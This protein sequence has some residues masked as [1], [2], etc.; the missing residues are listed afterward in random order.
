MPKVLKIK[1]GVEEGINDFLKFLLESGKVKGIFTL[2][3]TNENGAVSYSLITHLDELKKAVPLFPL[4]PVNAG[5]VLSAFTL[6]EATKDTVAAV[7]RPCEIRSFIELVKRFQ[8]SMENFLLISLTCGGV[9]PLKSAVNGE[10]KKLLPIYWE[11]IKKGNISSNIRPTCQTCEHFIPYQADMTIA[12]VEKK[13]TDKECNIFLNTDKGENFAKEAPGDIVFEEMDTNEITELKNKRK[14]Q[15]KKLYEELGIE[16]LEFKTLIKIFSACLSCHA[17]SHACPICYCTLCDFESKIFEY[18]P[19]SYN[20]EL[21]QKGGIRV[22]PGT[23]FFHIGRMVHMGVSCVGCGMCSDVCPVNIPVS[24]I[25]SMVG[26]SLQKMFEYLPGKDI[27]ES[28]PFG[29][30]KTEEFAEIG[31]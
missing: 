18:K 24:M 29:T 23:L 13:N 15:K 9:F 28:I 7:L 14:T 6:L 20:M 22:P 10:V 1:K 30:F 16:K 19:S 4:M 3:K 5:K 17:C 27:E 11:S 8:G 25:F 12:I 26:D 2:K 31:E 21:N